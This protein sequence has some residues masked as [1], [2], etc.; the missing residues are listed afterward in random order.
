[1]IKIKKIIYSTLIVL[2]VSMLGAWAPMSYSSGEDRYAN[3]GLYSMYAVETITYDSKDVNEKINRSPRYAALDGMTNACGAVAGA[4]VIAY[5]DKY[6]SEMI[7]GWQSYYPASGKYKLPDKVYI[8]SIISELY[9]LMRTNVD[10]VGVSDSD[11]VNGLTK[12]INSKG[13]YVSLKNV[14]YGTGIDY[15]SCKSAIDNN[16]VIVLLSRA[17]NVYNITDEGTHDRISTATISDLHIMV[18]SGYK[19]I[20]YYKGSSLFRTDK[21]LLASVGFR[22]IDTAYYKVNPHSL[23]YAYIVNIS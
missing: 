5:Y 3:A 20:K 19:E 10:G 7:P 6:Y 2:C 17:V 22:D 18:A 15:E 23:N 4:E 21:Y 14:V 9:S 16:K 11:F 13:Y 12:Y 8:P 1:M